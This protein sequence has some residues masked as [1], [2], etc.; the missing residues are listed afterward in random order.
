[1]AVKRRI[2]VVDDEPAILDLVSLVLTESGYEVSACWD[3]S[4]AYQFVR[5][6]QPDAAVLDMMMGRRVTGYD[7]LRMLAADESTA[8]VPIIVSSVLLDR[9][10]PALL[11]Y[12]NLF[13]LPK[14]FEL[15]ELLR[16]V[17]RALAQSDSRSRT[18]A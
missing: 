18:R 3:V 17:D 5:S 10:N 8:D 16:V 12:P 2:A 15:S 11:G 14:P 7:A 6:V 9:G 1:M 13:M 4:K